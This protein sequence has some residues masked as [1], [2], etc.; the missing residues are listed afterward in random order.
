[1]FMF[2]IIVVVRHLREHVPLLTGT[3]DVN[4]Q[5]NIVIR[6]LKLECGFHTILKRMIMIL[7]RKNDGIVKTIRDIVRNG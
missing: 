6:K 3:W 1:M 7:L 2:I 4:N 5:T